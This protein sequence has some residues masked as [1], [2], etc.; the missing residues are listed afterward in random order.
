LL[1][2]I[3]NW[4]QIP[5]FKFYFDPFM[6]AYDDLVA[7]LRR[8]WKA[9]PLHNSYYVERNTEMSNKIMELVRQYNIVKVLAGDELKRDQF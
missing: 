4:E 3:E 9:G 6:K 5:P 8:M 2:E 1:F 7:E